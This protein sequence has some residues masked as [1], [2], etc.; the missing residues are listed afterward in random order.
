MTSPPSAAAAS[1]PVGAVYQTAAV[2][3]RGIRTGTRGDHPAGIRTA[4][5]QVSEEFESI[6]LSQML[7]AMRRTVG[8][9]GLVDR[10]HGET[11]FT[12]MLDEE[13]ARKLAGSTNHGSI[14][15]LLYR[16][17]SRQ[18]GLSTGIDAPEGSDAPPMHQPL[19]EDSVVAC[20]S[21]GRK[22]R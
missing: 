15:D 20:G 10:S 8:D 17:L 4:L 16:Q 7:A 19:A 12:S 9:G 5:K 14:S 13:W 22:P 3:S 6:Y 21:T 2:M 1:A 18:M 11:I